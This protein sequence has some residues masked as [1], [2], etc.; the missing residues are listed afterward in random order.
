MTKQER[1]AGI[2]F[3]LLGA[4][5]VFYSFSQL[6]FGSLQRP[7]SGFFP[8]ICGTGILFLNLF[9]VL[10]NLKKTADSKPLWEKNEL[11]KPKNVHAMNIHSV[12]NTMII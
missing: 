2:F 1:I 6:K 5:V 8:V 4:A 3:A 7:G 12:I 11:K 10:K 9:W